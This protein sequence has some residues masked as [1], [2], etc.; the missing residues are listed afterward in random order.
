MNAIVHRDYSLDSRRIRLSMFKD[1][2][3]AKL[4]LAPSDA[5]V[6]VHS[7]GQPLAGVDILALFPNK[8]WQRATTDEAGEA[9]FS[10][11]TTH[12]PMTVYAARCAG[13]PPDSHGS[14]RRAKAAW[15][16]NWLRSR[17][18]ARWFSRRRPGFSRGCADG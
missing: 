1:R 2:Q 13:M 18:G 3:A 9:E 10:L 7:E 14:G 4:E 17:P 15:C 6:T 5:A 8:T 11:Y 12:L 16:W